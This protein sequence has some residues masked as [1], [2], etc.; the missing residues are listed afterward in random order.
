MRVTEDW[1][2]DVV[3]QTIFDVKTNNATILQPVLGQLFWPEGSGVE[4]SSQAASHEPTSMDE[5][6]GWTFC[7]GSGGVFAS[8]LPDI[9]F[10]AVSGTDQVFL[11]DRGCGC[12]VWAGHDAEGL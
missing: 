9:N 1:L 5:D 8:N 10:S 4:G 2:L 12:M 3:S 7:S 6:H 11:S